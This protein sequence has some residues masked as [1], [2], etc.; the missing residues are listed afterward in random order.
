[1]AKTNPS[2]K[3]NAVLPGNEKSKVST[4]IRIMD[5]AE[6]IVKKGYG[7]MECMK[8]AQEAY[9]ISEKQSERYYYGALNYL[10]PED[11]EGYREALISRNFSVME[12]LLKRAMDSNDTKT[13]L[14][15]VKAM[16]SLLGVGGKQVEIADKDKEGGE[17]KIVISF[18]D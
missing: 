4:T 12:E 17:K 9:G 6:L 11:P 7:R 10:R 14:D 16:N 18:G 5:I 15:V 2:R 1:M 13:A 8:Y 3:N